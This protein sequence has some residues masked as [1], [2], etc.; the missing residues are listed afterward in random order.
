MSHILRKVFAISF[1]C[2]F[3]W[4]YVFSFKRK[5]SR[6]EDD[7]SN[8]NSKSVVVSVIF[9]LNNCF[10]F[11]FF[12]KQEIEGTEIIKKYDAPEGTIVF[13][14]SLFNKCRYFHY[15]SYL[16]EWLREWKKI[17][18]RKYF[19]VNLSFNALDF[20]GFFIGMFSGYAFQKCC[21]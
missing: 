19:V 20:G 17:F 1:F 9:L 11:I 12:W 13:H 14:Q 18:G 7:S 2:T 16:I 21:S 8:N 10:F 3:L 4:W 6:L 5:W 15:Q